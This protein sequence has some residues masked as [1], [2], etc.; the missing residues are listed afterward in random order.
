MVLSCHKNGE[1]IQPV[2]YFFCD[3][4]E[5]IFFANIT[6]KHSSSMLRGPSDAL[7]NYPT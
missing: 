2:M 4:Y 3:L 7:I 1:T 5:Q 6:R